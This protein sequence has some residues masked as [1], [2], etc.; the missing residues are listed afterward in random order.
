MHENFMHNK[1]SQHYCK[2]GITISIS[3]M[4]NLERLTDS[5]KAT[6]QVIVKASIRA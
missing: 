2:T 3:Q 5:V 1:S 4:E 6:E